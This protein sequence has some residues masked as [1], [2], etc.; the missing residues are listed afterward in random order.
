M[1]VF[2]QYKLYASLHHSLKDLLRI[3]RGTSRSCEQR[4]GQNR[5]GDA[6][7]DGVGERPEAGCHAG[8]G[9]PGPPAG[10]S[11]GG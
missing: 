6:A 9:R 11:G 5:G 4:A 10:I 1:E 8:A 3:L 7:Q 2:T